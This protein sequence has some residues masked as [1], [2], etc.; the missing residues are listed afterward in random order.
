MGLKISEIVNSENI[1]LKDL[2]GKIVAIDAYNMLYQFLSIIRK[3]DGTPL[4]DNK[5]EITSH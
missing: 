4:L 1:S 5:G 2:K 3:Y